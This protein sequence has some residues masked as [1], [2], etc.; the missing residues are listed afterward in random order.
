MK[1]YLAKLCPGEAKGRHVHT[2]NHV[3]PYIMLF[4]GH[5]QV[6]FTTQELHA[7]HLLNIF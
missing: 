2:A 7:H 4:L 1:G 5:V 6:T 3:L